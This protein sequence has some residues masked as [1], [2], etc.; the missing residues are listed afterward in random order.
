M[1]INNAIFTK[2]KLTSIKEN[3]QSY[4]KERNLKSLDNTK[5][6]LFKDKMRS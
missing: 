3:W 5:R 1:P 2:R 6:A 4:S